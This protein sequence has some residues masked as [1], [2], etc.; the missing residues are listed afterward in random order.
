M[1]PF[2]KSK[3]PIAVGKRNKF[4]MSCQ[5]LTT[6]DFMQFGIAYNQV[7]VPN[8]SIS[9][10]HKTFFRANPLFKPVL[11]SAQVRNS[12]FFVPFRYVWRPFVDF[13]AQLPNNSDG[14]MS[15][16]VAVPQISEGVLAGVFT[17]T[18][19][20]SPS[21]STDYDLHISNTS[22]PQFEYVKFK[23]AG[24]F[25]YKFLKSLGY[26]IGDYLNRDSSLSFNALPFLSA[27]KV[28]M[29]WFYPQQYGHIAFAASIDSLFKRNV[30]FSLSV[31]EVVN[32]LANILYVCYKDDFWTSVWDNPVGPNT[33][34]QSLDIRI[35]DVTFGDMIA[36][37]N[38]ATSGSNVGYNKENVVLQNSNGTPYLS[39]SVANA[40]GVVVR[41]HAAFPLPTQYAIDSLK[42][43]TNYMKRKQLV[44]A[45]A[46]DRY[47]VQYGV[48]LSNDVLCRSIFLGDTSFPVEIGDVTSFA[49]TSSAN[50]A[51]LGSY[52]GKAIGYGEFKFDYDADDFGI[53][54]VVS[55]IVPDVA[56]VQGWRK[57]NLCL[58]P[59]DFFQGE[60]DN[61]GPDAV[62]SLELVQLPGFEVDEQREHIFGYATLY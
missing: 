14:N 37:Y 45:L 52:A 49:D 36:N 55:S 46:V 47:L 5:H 41:P 23:Y 57:F 24:R 7:V 48:R 2:S 51:S 60:F 44:G 3:V 53:V 42:A 19:F 28:Y 39:G 10:K 43:A 11:G 31:Q 29:D 32:C 20:V 30:S 62:S 15:I 25:A 58:T 38:S 21:N 16:D 59:L 56:Y 17:N 8:S 26:N 22:D 34:L 9:V 12:A 33:G 40:Q 18:A 61:L 50:G 13:I 6:A 1:T 54:I 35:P 27:V 4:D